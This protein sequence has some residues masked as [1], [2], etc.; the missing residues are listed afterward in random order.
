M[1]KIKINFP[2]IPPI[3]RNYMPRS[4]SYQNVNND[5]NLIRSVT[6]YFFESTTNRWLY[7]DFQDLIRHQLSKKYTLLVMMKTSAK[8]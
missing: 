2:L 5:K 4:Y 1:K 8:K 6:K 7:S 3:Y